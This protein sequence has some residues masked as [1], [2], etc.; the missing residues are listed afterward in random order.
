M[1]SSM[2]TSAS[3]VP[4]VRLEDL[5]GRDTVEMDLEPVRRELEGKV[6]LVTGAPARS[7]PNCAQIR[8]YR[9]SAL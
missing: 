3:P 1:K 8:P 4:E 5:L 6:V 9:R 2:E 7:G